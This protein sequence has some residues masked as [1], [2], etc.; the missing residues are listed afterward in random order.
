M[1][2][3]RAA[4]AGLAAAAVLLGTCAGLLPGAAAGASGSSPTLAQARK[5]LLTLADMPSGWTSTKNPGNPNDTT[6]DAQL[7]HCMGVPTSLISENPPSVN[8]RQFQN[9]QG[10]LMVT[11][12]VTVFPSTKNA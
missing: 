12:N 11:D 1:M 7:A 2:T 4:W 9:G 8:S 3:A 6:G 5:D 10:T